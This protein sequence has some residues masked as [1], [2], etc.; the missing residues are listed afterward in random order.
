MWVCGGILSNQRGVRRSIPGKILKFQHYESTFHGTLEL[1]SV[2]A[3]HMLE[4]ERV[5]WEE[6]GGEERKE[7]RGERERASEWSKEEEGN[8]GKERE[9][10]R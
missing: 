7:W 5:R 10:D 6:R 1:K 9:I 3:T 2:V 4:R 8:G